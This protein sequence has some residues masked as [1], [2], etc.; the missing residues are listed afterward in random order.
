M[1]ACARV[2]VCVRACACACVCARVC[3]RVRAAT[4]KPHSSK[5]GGTKSGILAAS[6]GVRCAGTRGMPSAPRPYL[7]ERT[8]SPS[9]LGR[10]FGR[11]V[12]NYRRSARETLRCTL[13]TNRTRGTR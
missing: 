7:P 9:V 13:A 8:R 6:G 12:P 5:L 4:W 11:I 3:V 10:Y 2:R 1:R